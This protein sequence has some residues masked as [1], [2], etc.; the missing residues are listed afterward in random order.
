LADD[1]R[2][3]FSSLMTLLIEC[4][5]KLQQHYQKASTTMHNLELTSLLA[6]YA[7]EISQSIELMQKARVET[8]VEMALEP[9]TD[10]KLAETVRSID[11]EIEVGYVQELVII[12]RTV[13]Q[14]YLQ[15]SPKVANMSAEASELLKR[16][17][18]DS[19]ER[20]HKLAQVPACHGD[21][22]YGGSP[23][24]GGH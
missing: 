15:A 2:Y 7:K 18:R 3:T 13:S 17:S 9:I 5:R 20:A 11:G 4:E 10:L 23:C 1:E 6:E 12:E 14:L 24:S 16:L 19:V 22:H 8:V 21:S